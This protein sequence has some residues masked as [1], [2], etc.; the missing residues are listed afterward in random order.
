MFYALHNATFTVCKFGSKY[1][2]NV[3][4]VFDFVFDNQ[5]DSLFASMVNNWGWLSQ[6][7]GI[8]NKIIININ[9]KE[10]VYE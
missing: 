1:N 10:D 6:N 3:Y 2:V 4:D 8:F 5:Y 9:F 7:T